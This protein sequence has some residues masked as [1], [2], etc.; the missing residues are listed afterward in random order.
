M[1]YFWQIPN[2][3][4]KVHNFLHFKNHLPAIHLLRSKLTIIM[5]SVRNCSSGRKE[6]DTTWQYLSVTIVSDHTLMLRK[7]DAFEFGK[8]H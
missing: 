6:A 4:L 7:L 5:K 8:G 2:Y 3:S 1:K